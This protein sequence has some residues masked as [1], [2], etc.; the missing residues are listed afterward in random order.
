MRRLRWRTST[1]GRR[2]VERW[3]RWQAER[4]ATD[5][6]QVEAAAH[7]REHERQ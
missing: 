4:R 3:R 7:W 1:I 5:E 2:L 6:A